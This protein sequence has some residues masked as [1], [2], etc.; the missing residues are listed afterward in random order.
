MLI[1]VI[2]AST[3]KR[4]DAAAMAAAT[5]TAATSSNMR[6][7]PFC[8]AGAAVVALLPLERIADRGESA[9]EAPFGGVEGEGGEGAPEG[10]SLCG[11]DMTSWL[12]A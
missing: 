9:S 7:C 8:R 10:E 12:K 5:A 2:G 1:V 4:E 6:L 11:V 3:P